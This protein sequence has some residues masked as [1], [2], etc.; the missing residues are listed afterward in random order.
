M[1]RNA[2]HVRCALCDG[3]VA[4]HETEIDARGEL[5]CVRCNARAHVDEAL[6]RWQ[7]ES[8]RNQLLVQTA[9]WTTY[10][11]GIVR[12]ILTAV[13]VIVALSP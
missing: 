2:T 7:R 6:E 3:L 4:V 5:V 12:F 11:G 10:P 8:P 1:Y 13:L 9:L